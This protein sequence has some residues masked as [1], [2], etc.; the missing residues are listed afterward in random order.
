MKKVIVFLLLVF[1]FSAG[2]AQ[3]TLI[4][5]AQ[6]TSEQAKAEMEEV[7]RTVAKSE[8]VAKKA[9]K[10]AAA[11]NK[12]DKLKKKYNSRVKAIDKQEKKIEKLQKQFDK[13]RL[14]STLSPL[15]MQKIE[16]RIIKI[17]LHIIKDQERLKKLKR[18]I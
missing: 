11:K 5:T 13:W 2:H 9:K 14:K 7:R 8:A 12:E 18:K 16:N 3:G 17:Q 1:M 10:E 6:S 4:E 15:D